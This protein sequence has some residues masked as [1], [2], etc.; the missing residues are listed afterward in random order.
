MASL[1][2][3]LAMGNPVAFEASA[4]L[5]DTR[6]FISMTIMRP[7]AGLT[8]NWMFE[9]PVSTPISRMTARA[10]SR[11]IW[12]SLSVRVMAGAAGVEWPGGAP[13]R[14]QVYTEQK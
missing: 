5:R 7:L 13:P 3:I 1:V 8:A 4:E 6:V 2:A 12:Y 9:P 14:A 10:A 11:M